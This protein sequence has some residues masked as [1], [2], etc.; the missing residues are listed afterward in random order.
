M[1]KEGG[2]KGKRDRKREG[3]K[4]E[5]DRNGNTTMPQM[6]NALEDLRRRQGNKVHRME[7]KIPVFVD[8]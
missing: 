3:E 2:R 1:K 8:R 5:R 6:L 4:K 7:R